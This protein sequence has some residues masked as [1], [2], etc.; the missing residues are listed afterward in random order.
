MSQEKCVSDKF[1][2][3]QKLSKIFIVQINNKKI[4]CI[5]KHKQSW[6]FELYSFQKGFLAPQFLHSAV[7]LVLC[8]YVTGLAADSYFRSTVYG[9]GLY[10]IDVITDYLMPFSITGK[11]TTNHVIINKASAHRCPASIV[12]LENF[13]CN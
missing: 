13:L 3:F 5:M 2:A 4:K 1:A 12:I 7:D 8:A 9:Q 6:H 10:H 11:E